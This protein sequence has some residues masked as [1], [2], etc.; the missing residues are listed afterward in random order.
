MSLKKVRK[1]DNAIDVTQG[2]IHK[3]L[4]QLMWPIF[5]S[6]L[7]QNM[8]GIFNSLIVGR[9]AGKIA[10]GGIQVTMPL[11]DLAV[12]LSLGIGAGCG[13]IVGQYFGEHDDKHLSQSSHTAMAISIWG[14]LAA[15]VIGMFCVRPLLVLMGTPEELMSQA[16]DFGLWYFGALVFSIILNMGAAV[17]RA[18]GDS[19]TP[20]YVISSTCVTNI[21]L[22][23]VFVAKLGMEAKGCGIATAISIATGAVAILHVLHKAEGPWKIEYNKLHAD[24]KICSIM[25]KTGIPLGIQAGVYSVSNMIAQAAV[26]SFG[27]DAITSWGLALR[28]DGIIWMIADSLGIAVTAFCAQNFGARN[29]DRMKECLKVSLLFTVFGIGGM[30]ALIYATVPSI[31]AWFIDDTLVTNETARMIRVIIPFILFYSVADSYSGV[32]RSAGESVGPMILTIFGT[33]ILRIAW[34]FIMVPKFK[35]ID[36]VLYSYPMSWVV[37][38]ALMAI[39][40]HKGSWLEH[41]EKRKEKNAEALKEEALEAAA[42]NA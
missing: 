34:I 11:M 15:S 7:F 36:M 20:L 40:Y 13:V 21:V 19:K 25:L 9:F 2:V 5:L 22:D 10:L 14:G 31:A 41:S 33:C 38:A 6:F 4:A 28:I 30:A 24:K 3:Q 1:K 35:V 27:A 29:Y 37:T 32:I 42:S 16:M 12:A 26:N 39:Y 8:Y 23:Y 18:I 17:L